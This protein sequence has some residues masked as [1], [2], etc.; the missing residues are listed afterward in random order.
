MKGE[1]PDEATFRIHGVLIKKKV[2]HR[3]SER[4][5]GADLYLVV[6]GVK[7]ALVQFKVGMSRYN[8]DMDEL[9][10]LEKFCEL[11]VVDPNRPIACPV[12]VC[13]IKDNG[14]DLT[15]RHRILK[16][17]QLREVLGS[18][19][20]AGVQEFYH[21]GITR[22]NF[23]ELL[24]T[25]WEGAPFV[26]RPSDNSLLDYAEKLNRLLVQYNVSLP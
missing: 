20:S 2:V 21:E 19:S 1:K 16:V 18:R 9:G 25:C 17:C 8:F 26:R 24:A 3:K 12:F 6:E 22:D 10:N 13:L 15:P 4:Y 11:C 14:P 7:F 5:N 23:K